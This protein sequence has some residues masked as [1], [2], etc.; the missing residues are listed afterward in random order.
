MQTD[1]DSLWES[2]PS[3]LKKETYRTKDWTIAEDVNTFVT[4]TVSGYAPGHDFVPV[5]DLNHLNKG[6]F[7]LLQLECPYEPMKLWVARV[8]HV[9]KEERVLELTQKLP[10][11]PKI[12]STVK[13]VMADDETVFSERLTEQYHKDIAK[14]Q[15]HRWEI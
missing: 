12:G 1:I 6:N 15:G 7:I 8:H 4:R 14:G 9:N 3:R 10:F 5:F 2:F 13:K 11:L